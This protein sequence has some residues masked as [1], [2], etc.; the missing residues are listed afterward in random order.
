MIDGYFLINKLFLLSVLLYVRIY[1]TRT[2][3]RACLF[4]LLCVRNFTDKSSGHRGA[5]VDLCFDFDLALSQIG[6]FVPIIP[7]LLEH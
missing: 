2:R 3:A 6:I 4:I 5:I 1:T 7:T